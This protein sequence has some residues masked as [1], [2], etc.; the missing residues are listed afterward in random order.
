MGLWIV[1]IMFNGIIESRRFFKYSPFVS[2]GKYLVY[3]GAKDAM[4][5]CSAVLANVLHKQEVRERFEG[6]KRRQPCCFAPQNIFLILFL[7]L[8]LINH[9]GDFFG[10][11]FCTLLYCRLPTVQQCVPPWVLLYLH[12]RWP[13]SYIQNLF[14]LSVNS[15][16]LTESTQASKSSDDMINFQQ[17]TTECLLMNVN[18]AWVW[19][20][21]SSQF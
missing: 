4:I 9:S 6:R 20:L 10:W 15:R 12:I 14:F 18:F 8:P 3:D 11:Q 19:C 5:D 7:S 21:N 17:H 16:F 1:Q 2:H 13:R